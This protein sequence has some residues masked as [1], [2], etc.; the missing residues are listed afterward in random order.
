M[1]RNIF[2]VS[3]FIISQDHRWKDRRAGTHL[4]ALCMHFFFSSSSSDVHGDC[5]D[6]TSSRHL[7][8]TKPFREESKGIG[9]E[10]VLSSQRWEEVLSFQ[11][12]FNKKYSK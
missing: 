4:T 7:F 5:D 9:R 6:H 2:K 12:Q 11:K 3:M 10:E 8:L 1:Q